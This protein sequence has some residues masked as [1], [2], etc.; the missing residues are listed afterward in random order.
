MDNGYL[1]VELKEKF[2]RDIGRSWRFR[3]C[4]GFRVCVCVC[5]CVRARI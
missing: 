2:A 3:C 4:F 5:V 1:R